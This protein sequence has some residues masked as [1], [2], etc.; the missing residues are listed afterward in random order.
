MGY[1]KDEI[2]SHSFRG[3]MSTI[4]HSKMSEHGFDSL[5][6][7]KALSHA[8]SNKVRGSYAHSDL[9]DEP[10]NIM[11]GLKHALMEKM[12]DVIAGKEDVDSRVIDNYVTY[13]ELWGCTSCYACVEACPYGAITVGDL[14]DPNSKINQ[15]LRENFTIRRKTSLG[16]GPSV[17]YI[18]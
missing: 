8:D 12:P 15:L 13:E 7:E 17:F 10:N 16:T 4:A 11:N 9:F 2:V 6:I 14:T 5:V 18:V 1:T 3:I